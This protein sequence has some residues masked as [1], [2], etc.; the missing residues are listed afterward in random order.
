VV[1][2]DQQLL[3]AVAAHA[4]LISDELNVKSVETSTDEG[5]LAHLSVKPNFRVLGPRFGQQMKEAAAAVE[6]LDAATVEAV[7]AGGTVDVLGQALG[8][9]DLIVE[10]VARSG[11]AVATGDGLSVALDTELDGDLLTE[12][13][14]REL[15]KTIQGLRREAGLDVSDRISVT[16]NATHELVTAAFA[17][18]GQWI[19]S[20]TL[21]TSIEPGADLAATHALADGIDV[22]LEI[23]AV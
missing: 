6:T 10:R 5:S 23:A 3:D 17:T 1:S 14:A 20:E 9:N 19:A 4:E 8:L 22:D 12:G 7:I 11:V 15:V 18:H 13:V 21:A 2:H 16:W